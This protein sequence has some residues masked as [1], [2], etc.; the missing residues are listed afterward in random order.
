V[1]VGRS[2]LFA[3]WTGYALFVLLLSFSIWLHLGL[4]DYAF[5]DAY[6]HFR[7]AE[8]LLEQGAPYYNSGEAVMASSSP[9]W[10]LLLSALFLV[11]GSSAGFVAILN[12]VIAAL[13]ALTFVA[14]ARELTAGE[15]GKPLCWAF[16]LPYL[17][18]IHFSSTG[19]METALALL[20]L[21]LGALLYA[22]RR[23]PLHPARIRPLLSALLP[24][25]IDPPQTGYRPPVDLCAA[26]LGAD[27]HL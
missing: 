4:H 27:H 11:T 7:V 5:D 10:T 15:L 18:L 8:Q 6:I 24:A 22:R 9:V 2:P 23:D 26:R 17:S 13:G 1:S 19:L 16:A 25:C 20:V 3:G 12:G 14:L 21:G